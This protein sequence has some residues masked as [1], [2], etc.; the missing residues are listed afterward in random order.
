[1]VSE[2]D[3]GGVSVPSTF[4]LSDH[5]RHLWGVRLAGEQLSVGP[6]GWAWV[7]RLGESTVATAVGLVWIF[8]GFGP[9]TFVFGVAM[10]VGA[11]FDAWRRLRHRV[12][13]GPG[14]LEV[15]YGTFR[16]ASLGWAQVA[17][18]RVGWN[19]WSDRHSADGSSRTWEFGFLPISSGYDWPVI[20]TSGGDRVDVLGL[21]TLAASEGVAAWGGSGAEERVRLVRR[22]LAHSGVACASEI[23]VLR[24]W[25]GV[26]FWLVSLI[27]ACGFLGAIVANGLL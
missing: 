8:A 20:E 6:T 27:L 18:V 4:A 15:R 19:R 22:Y 26:A 24:S 14:G 21:A 1:M 11:W 3:S 9:G 23:R 10:V 2:Q 25:P 16:S 17:D 7:A 12:V 13:C 5:E